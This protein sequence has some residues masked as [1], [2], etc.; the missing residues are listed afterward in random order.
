M[1]IAEA[2]KYAD[3]AGASGKDNTPF[4]LAKIKELTGGKSVEANRA[5]IASNVTRGTIVAKE[6]AAIEAQEDG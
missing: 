6:L 2:I 3:A 4:V 1:V 5:L